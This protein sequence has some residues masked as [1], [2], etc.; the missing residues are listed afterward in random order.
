MLNW[1]LI[2]ISLVMVVF[3]GCTPGTIT[4][5]D[6]I[7][8]QDF[9]NEIALGNIDG[10]YV[11]HKFGASDSVGTTIA[12]VSIGGFYRT[13][14]TATT[15]EVLSDNANDNSGGT[16]ARV[17]RIFGLNASGHE[18]YEDVNLSGVTPVALSNSYLRVYMWYVLESGSYATATTPSQLGTLTI[19]ETGGGQTWSI[20][21]VIGGGFG[22]GQSEIGVYS[23]P[24]DHTC[25][26]LKK[27]MS[28]NS[29]KAANIYFFQRQ[30]LTDTTAPY[31]AMRLVE[32]HIGVTAVEE[33]TSRSA[34]NKFPELTDIGFMAN[35]E[36]GTAEVSV[37]F[38]MVCL[39]NN[40]FNI[41]N[42]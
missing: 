11:V 25:W 1:K 6:Y 9:L 40:I 37:E 17:V 39:N 5:E 23:I 20:L 22:V 24:K 34:I 33:I 15:L 41:S 4:I 2:L 30:N 7:L 21:N 31:S 12:P 36:T 16:G 13:P 38:E 32:K 27:V 28:V 18:I 26:L 3:A 14:T 8:N 35:T 10:A 19:R 29:N 42:S